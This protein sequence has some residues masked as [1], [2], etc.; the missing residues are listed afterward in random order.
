MRA[1]AID[2]FGTP[3][4]LHDLP[5]LRAGAN[6]IVVAVTVAG[7]NPIDWKIRDGM[8]GERPLPLVLGQDFAGVVDAVGDG[9]TSFKKGERVFG[10]AREHGGYADYTALSLDDHGSPVAATPDELDDVRAAAIPTAGLTALAG[11][12]ALDAE[13]GRSVLI[14]G[15]TGGVGAFATQLA[16]VRGARIV[17]TA[18]EKNH[19]FALSLG[20]G[21]V[22]D[23]DREDVVE[24]VKAWYPEGVDGIFDL[25]SK[26]AEA[27][28]KMAALLVP[29]GKLVSTN[30]AADQA[31]FGERGFAALNI[32]LAKTPQSSSESLTELARLVT[33]G[34]IQVFVEQHA[35][36]AD[37][38][39]ILEQSRAGK[40]GGK[41]V[42]TVTA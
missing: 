20:A 14:L 40:V 39:A 7:V 37:A 2:E 32:S 35:P 29:G 18:S 25:V 1:F 17:A 28:E 16:R 12:V 10:I 27:V 31:W 24:T 23:Y 22:A 33:A 11:L 30:H 26:D 9:V 13:N 8:A 19:D 34:T 15:A 6:E 3:G 4:S 41:A 42:L 21:D 36:L 5:A 38:A